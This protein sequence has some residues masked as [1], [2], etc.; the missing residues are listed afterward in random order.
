MANG[1]GQQPAP[2]SLGGF[3]GDITGM[4]QDRWW[5]KEAEE[6]K[7]S[8][9]T[10]FQEM[11]GRIGQLTSDETF[12]DIGGLWGIYT[13]GIK[14]FMDRAS[15]YPKN[16]Y[17]SQYGQN[18]FNFM[19]TQFG[20]LTEGVQRQHQMGIA[21]SEER[22]AVAA[23]PGE[24][25]ETEARTGLLRAQAGAAG[26]TSLKGLGLTFGKHDLFARMS[27]DAHIGTIKQ[28]KAYQSMRTNKI[29]QQAAEKWNSIPP[30]DRMLTATNFE[31]FVKTQSLSD[32]DEVALEREALTMHFN[33]LY[34]ASRS[35]YEI[36]ALIDKISGPKHVPTNDNKEKALFGRIPMGTPIP[37][38]S[39]S[40]AKVTFMTDEEVPEDIFEN[41]PEPSVMKQKYGGSPAGRVAT[42]YWR[43]RDEDKMSHEHAVENMFR[44]EDH[45]GSGFIDRQTIEVFSGIGEGNSVTDAS[46]SN[47]RRDLL[48]M[49]RA[50]EDYYEGE[51][52]EK[53]LDKER[54][55]EFAR[56]GKMPTLM[57][58][59][60]AHGIKRLVEEMFEPETRYSEE[61]LAR[62]GMRTDRIVPPR[63]SIG[64]ILSE[65]EEA[66][67]KLTRV[68]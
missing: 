22:R 13:A 18:M 55:E 5:K 28:S 53:T 30:A 45:G 24:R 11:L 62:E 39:V 61:A 2:D 36:E 17:I 48:K 44:S 26:K 41:P 25:A 66:F 27:P 47:W 14:K 34:G 19:Q 65:Q 33:E 37:E 29:R 15:E 20:E 40:S 68:P 6:F 46:I 57:G 21:A 59:R 16:P 12:S 8:A 51:M 60:A 52:W 23:A 31:N 32:E 64:T 7:E 56:T 4:V 3:V 49:L 42:E 1:Q 9:G 10:E 43:L 67:P 58:K 54:K 38:G 63:E 35:P 50:Y